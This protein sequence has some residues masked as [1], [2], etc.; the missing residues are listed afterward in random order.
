[1]RD[2]TVPFIDLES[3]TQEALWD[4]S[5]ARA[6]L[7]ATPH[8]WLGLRAQYIFEKFERDE[9]CDGSAR[10]CLTVG[11]RNVETQRVPLGISFFHPSGLSASLTATYWHQEGLFEQLEA[12]EFAPGTSNFWLFDAA[13]NFRLP[14]FH[15]SAARRLVRQG[16]R[17]SRS[18]STPDH[19][20]TRRSSQNHPAVPRPQDSGAGLNPKEKRN[21]QEITC[22]WR[23]RRQLRLM[24]QRAMHISPGRYSRP[25]ATSP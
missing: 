12:I 17:I 15:L 3:V 24:R 25:T 4:E 5:M 8:R 18:T 10:E 13:V 11:F 2:L 22:D 16:L 23:C 20:P 21:V 14:A 7:F 1:M 19:H 6:Y 9:E